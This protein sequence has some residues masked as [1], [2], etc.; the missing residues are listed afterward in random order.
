MYTVP[1]LTSE[2]TYKTDQVFKAVSHLTN[3]FE[4]YQY[5]YQAIKPKVTELFFKV[6]KQESFIN[7]ET[8]P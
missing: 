8:F 3:H 4:I 5:Y 2:I 6:T 7:L 1:A